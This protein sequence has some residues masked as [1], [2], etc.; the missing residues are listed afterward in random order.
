MYFLNHAKVWTSVSWSSLGKY[1]I[2]IIVPDPDP[3]VFEPPGS[4]SGS[5]I[6]LYGS[7]H[8]Q[9]K[10]KKTLISTVLWLFYDFLSLMND[11]NPPSKRIKHSNLKE[12]FSFLLASWRSLTKR[13][14]SGAGPHP[15]PLIK[16]PDPL[17]K[18]TSPWI[19]N[20]MSR[21]RNTDSDPKP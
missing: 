18:G 3:Y 11:V 16:G 9:A 19:R 14:G 5:V 10:M 21:I 20:Q 7:F 15:D 12:I 1:S 2:Q 6:C 17:I 13:A 8:Q 4:A